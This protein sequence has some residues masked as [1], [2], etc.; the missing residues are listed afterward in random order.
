ME[1]YLP[2]GAEP[3]M[4]LSLLSLS[5][6]SHFRR[7][8]MDMLGFLDVCRE[9]GVDGAD[10]HEAAF[11]SVTRADLF[12][13]KRA[14]LDRGLD[15]PCVSISNNF[16]CPVDELAAAVVHTKA[17]IQR[18]A[19]LGAPQVRV[20]S[21]RP[22]T[23]ADRSASWDRCADALRDCAQFGATEGVV[24]ALQNHNHLQIAP[25]GEDVIRL[26]NQVDHPN[27]G[28]VLDT[29]QYAGSPGASGYGDDDK[30]GQ[31]DYLASIRLTAPLA[32]HVRAKLYRIASG[33]E[34]LLDYDQI[35][36]IL[37]GLGYNGWVSLVYE[38][39][40]VLGRDDR[41]DDALE[42]IPLGVRFLRGH[43]SAS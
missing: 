32:T 2:V 12:S 39:E 34:E 30:G 41:V 33:V 42:V 10:L 36:S 24:V 38:G 27:L 3:I 21:G 7:G 15:I 1:D 19:L 16:A 25:D 6:A 4:K 31:H 8:D 22:A 13:I 26:I 17:W 14:C 5:Y 11:A 43:L 18:A 40:R 37:R 35:F 9:L 20:F 23:E 29:G 28:H